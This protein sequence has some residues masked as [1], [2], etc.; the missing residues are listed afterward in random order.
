MGR[1]YVPSTA[2]TRGEAEGVQR[3]E[4]SPESG[5]SVEQLEAAAEAAGFRLIPLEV[6]EP[7]GNASTEAWVNYAKSKGATD[8]D[9][10][11]AEGQPLK[12]DELRDKFGTPSA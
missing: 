8:E 11:D 12:R 6:E 7:A 1:L 4:V 9:L 10:V 3:G 2:A 5:L